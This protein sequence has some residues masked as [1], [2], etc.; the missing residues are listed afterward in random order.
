LALGK[1]A[2][3]EGN[4]TVFEPVKDHRGAG[5]EDHELT[6]IFHALTSR[7]ADPAELFRRDPLDA[8]LPAL[9]PSG[10]AAN[11]MMLH[12]V[13]NSGPES[14]FRVP[15]HAAGSEA[16]S[17]RGRM[18]PSDRVREQDRLDEQATIVLG[19]LPRH[20]VHDRDSAAST[21]R[22]GRHRVLRAVDHSGIPGR[23]AR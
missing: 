21:R 15:A 18:V 17:R 13:E 12:P 19:R 8:P 14:G 6:P 22:G 11:R 23:G 10:R 9:A 16:G 20:S 3:A 7:R 4:A 2:A 1:H 5:T